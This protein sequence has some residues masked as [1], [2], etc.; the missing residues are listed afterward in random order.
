MW[1]LARGLTQ[2]PW[3]HLRKNI[4][5]KT[6]QGM[7]TYPV[8]WEGRKTI[9]SKLAFQRSFVS[10]QEGK[11]FAFTQFTQSKCSWFIVT[12]GQF[13]N[14]PEELILVKFLL[15]FHFPDF[16][17]KQHTNFNPPNPIPSG[18]LQLQNQNVPHTNL[19]VTLLVFP[20]C[21]LLFFCWLAL[22]LVQLRA[23]L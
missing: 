3:I 9:D 4:R 13:P 23:L 2:G 16:Q 21:L 22:D 11:S 5:R 10:S 20:R 1:E 14:N 18:L 6:L 7:D 17:A 15:H 8:P 19:V 12:F